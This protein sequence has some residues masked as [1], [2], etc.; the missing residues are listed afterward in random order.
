[1]RRVWRDREVELKRCV[2]CKKVQYCSKE[3]QGKAWK[4][5][6]KEECKKSVASDGKKKR[7]SGNNSRRKKGG[8]SADQTGSTGVLA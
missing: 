1:M 4:K 3:C 2:Q 8:K 7:R 5:G 6:H